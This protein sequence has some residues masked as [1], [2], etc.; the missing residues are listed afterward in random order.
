MSPGIVYNF[1]VTAQNDAGVSDYSDVI[2]VKA[3]D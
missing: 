3:A 1:K 2:E